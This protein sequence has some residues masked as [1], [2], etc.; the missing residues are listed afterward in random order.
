LGCHA[1]ES[2]A[3]HGTPLA[4]TTLLHLCVDNDEIDIASWLLQRG[5]DVNTRAEVDDDG[6]GGHTALFGCVV[7]QPFR[8]G[9]RTDDTFARLLLDPP[10]ET[11][12]PAMQAGLVS[13][14]MNWSDIF[15]AP[16]ALY[17]LFVAVVRV[18]IAV[19]LMETSPAALSTFSWPHE[20]RSAA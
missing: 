5:A 14:P 6:Y 11:R 20:H 17:V 3:L 2:L 4:G 18:P 13:A 9:L 12:T 8:V 16:A 7:S 1:D 19:Q 10:R 15:T